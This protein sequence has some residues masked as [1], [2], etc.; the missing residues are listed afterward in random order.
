MGVFS[1]LLTT[2]DFLFHSSHYIVTH[3]DLPS[4]IKTV[5]QYS[6]MIIRYVINACKHPFHV[7]EL[8]GHLLNVKRQKSSRATVFFFFFGWAVCNRMANLVW[9][10][11]WFPLCVKIIAIVYHAGNSVQM[12][13]SSVHA[14]FPN[15]CHTNAFLTCANELYAAKLNGVNAQLCAQSCPSNGNTV[16]LLYEHEHEDI[17]NKSWWCL[18][19]DGQTLLANTSEA[20]FDTWGL[21]TSHWSYNQ[22]GVWNLNF[23]WL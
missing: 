6:S 14:K 1:S 7:F 20:P 3:N 18:C 17:S 16:L 22:S 11:D 5:Q 4:R 13:F 23:N 10:R 21:G 9:A 15:Q 8:L 19:V 12:S 2:F